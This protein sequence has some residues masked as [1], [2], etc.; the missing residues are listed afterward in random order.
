MK[1]GMGRSLTLLLC[2]LF[3]E[4]SRFNS[5]TVYFS[6]SKLIARQFR[7]V[8]AIRNSFAKVF[9]DLL[10]RQLRK[11]SEETDEKLLGNSRNAVVANN[12]DYFRYRGIQNISLKAFFLYIISCE[13]FISYDNDNVKLIVRKFLNNVI[14]I[15]SRF[16]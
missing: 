16:L 14:L 2:L 11:R 13:I 1:Y 9:Q 7:F 10:S 8:R 15:R 12:I 5:Q 3:L 6:F 4:V